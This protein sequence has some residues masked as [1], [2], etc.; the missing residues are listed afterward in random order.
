MSNFYPETRGWWWSL[1]E[2]YL[3]SRAVGREEHCEQ[4]SLACVGSA[5]SVFA[6]LSLP[7][8]TACVFPVYTVKALGCSAGNC[9]RWAPGLNVL[10]RSKLLR[11]RFRFSGTPQRCRLA[12]ACILCPSQ[13]WT[14]QVIRCLASTGT[15]S[16][17]LWLIASSIPAT[18]FSGYT[19][20]MSSQVCRV[21]LLGRWSLAATLL[22]DID[23]PE[24]QVLVSNDA[25][26]KF[27]RWCLSGA[28]I[29]PFGL[30]LPLPAC[31]QQGM[32]Q[33]TAGW[34]CSVLCSVSG[35]GGVLA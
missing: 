31:L 24:S 28:A 35:P 7:P 26:L 27:G 11:F 19:T 1:F 16:W 22:V 17:G 12:W 15:P 20:R 25:C 2:A 34:V 21:S 18:G 30:W 23:H 3:F 4:I 14:A 10:P 13:V 6:T 5:C 8:L 29:A 33:S 32:G 9:L